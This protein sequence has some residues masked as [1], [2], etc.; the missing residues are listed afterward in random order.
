MSSSSR[1]I[2]AVRKDFNSLVTLLGAWII[3]KHRNMCVFDGCS[4]S[5]VVALR[6]AR[7]EVVLWSLTEI[8]ALS[9][10][11]IDELLL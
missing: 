6:A 5:L 7:E 8:K 10:V 9:F 1:V 4:P 3:W 2:E 11:Q